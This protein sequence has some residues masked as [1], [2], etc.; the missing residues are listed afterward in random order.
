MRKALKL[1]V[2][3]ALLC[4][5]SVLGV[6]QREDPCA[7]LPNNEICHYQWEAGLFCCEP[8]SGIG[9]PEYCA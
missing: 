8:I 1:L 2:L 9:C 3:V 6:S 4:T 7:G 5:S